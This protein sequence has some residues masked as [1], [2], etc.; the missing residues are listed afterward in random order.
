MTTE[1]TLIY[2]SGTSDDE[3]ADQY[4]QCVELIEQRT[5]KSL[6]DEGRAKHLQM[7]KEQATIK[8]PVRERDDPIRIVAHRMDT[9]RDGKTANDVMAE[10]FEQ[11]VGEMIVAESESHIIQN[12]QQYFRAV[13]K[14]TIAAKRITIE[15]GASTEH[16]HRVLAAIK[17]HETTRD[18]DV[19]LK[20]SWPGGRPP[21]GT[22]VVDGQLIK[23][24]DY[25]DV[26]ETLRRVVFDDLSKSAASRKIGCTRKTIG[27]TINKRHDLFDIPHQ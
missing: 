1:Q 13:D 8:V 16:I 24:D 4:E 10:C 25:H 14:I 26:R 3:I 7:L 12:I 19:I 2:L 5:D 6:D 18:G 17:D 23:D 11:G 22:E 20:D 15:Q 27:N 9:I 21:I